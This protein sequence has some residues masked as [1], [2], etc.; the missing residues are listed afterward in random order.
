MKVQRR[1]HGL[2]GRPVFKKM[3]TIEKIFSLFHGERMLALL[4]V[5]EYQ[6]LYRW[7]FFKGP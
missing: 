5:P 6:F 1:P 4:E 3:S 7:F 2:H